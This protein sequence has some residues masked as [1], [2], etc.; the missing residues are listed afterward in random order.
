MPM[1]SVESN[2]LIVKVDRV[3]SGFALNP[4]TE[5]DSVRCQCI[6][7]ANFQDGTLFETVSSVACPREVLEACKEKGVDLY[8][9]PSVLLHI[10]ESLEVTVWHDFPLLAQAI[11]LRLSGF[12]K[13]D[14]IYED[15]MAGCLDVELPEEMPATGRFGYVGRVGWCPYACFDFRSDEDR[16]DSS[17]LSFG[18][19]IAKSNSRVRYQKRW[20]LFG[21]S[22][23]QLFEAGWFPFVR[24]PKK[25]ITSLAVNHQCGND[26]QGIEQE[27]VDWFDEK[28]FGDVLLNQWAGHQEMK[29]L[30]NGLNTVFDRYANDDYISVI[31]SMFPLIEGFVRR[32]VCPTGKRF[33]QR[34]FR[35]SIVHMSLRISP[36]NTLFLPDVFELYLEKFF[37]VDFLSSDLGNAKFGRHSAMHGALEHEQ[38]TRHRCVQLFLILDQLYWLLRHQD[39][40]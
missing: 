29:E 40:K 15:D 14:P 4:V 18:Q 12:E 22:R 17:F 28:V 24:M 20:G 1:K 11:K 3:P 5:G 32:V 25:F 10:S 38:M 19:L 13:D 30:K 8:R 6:A 36:M 26:L 37:H 7:E 39:G 34:D 16:S 2:A 33:G 27:I 31:Y 21:E 35:Q 23:D 9:S